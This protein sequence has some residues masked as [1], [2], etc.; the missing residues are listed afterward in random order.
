MPSAVSKKSRTS[1][2]SAG[3]GL[4]VRLRRL[5]PSELPQHP[6]LAAYQTYHRADPKSF[7]REV[8]NEAE[9]F[10]TDYWS[11]KFK[12][13][14]SKKSSPP[15]TAPVELLIH[16]VHVDDMPEE[17]RG[18]AISGIAETWFAR[19]SIHENKA[20]KGTAEWAEFERYLLDDH[21]EHEKDYT[22]AVYDAHKVLD[23]GSTGLQG[24]EGWEKV[25]MSIFEMCHSMP[26]PLSNRTFSVIVVKARSTRSPVSFITAQIPV[27]ISQTQVALYSNGR[28]EEEG[29]GEQKKPVTP[30]IYVS[31]ERCELID[32]GSKVKWQMTTA[33]DAKGVLPMAIQKL[34][35][36]GAVVK[37]VG[38]FTEWVDLKR[39]GMTW[40]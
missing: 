8:L 1:S 2:G 21:S 34:G 32:D 6:E 24:I 22:P 3:L 37:D 28:H 26:P 31:V 5:S 14:S 40:T 10:A 39:E 18:G 25:E 27:D 15:S 7:A 20:K 30:G 12:V 29:R 33:S 36:P 23:W 9:S 35:V 4:R 38:L 11:K 16:D 13:K 17:V 19:S